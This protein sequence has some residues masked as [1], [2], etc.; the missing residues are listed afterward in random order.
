MN[1]TLFLSYT[2]HDAERC[3]HRIDDQLNQPSADLFRE[4]TDFSR[5]L[6]LVWPGSTPE[7]R[8]NQFRLACYHQDLLIQEASCD[9]LTKGL[10]KLGLPSGYLT[11]PAIIATFHV[12]SYRILGQ[13]LAL[14]RIPFSLLVSGA[15]K[16]AQEAIYWDTVS[17]HL[18]HETD[19]A[20][21]NA[22]DPGV[23]FAMRRS[24][25]AGHC[26][27][28]YLDGNVGGMSQSHLVNLGNLQFRVPLGIGFLAHLMDVP[29]FPIWT[30]RV[31]DGLQLLLK[32]PYLPLQHRSRDKRD[33]ISPAKL[34]L[35]ML[36]DQFFKDLS[37]APWQ[38]EGWFYLDDFQ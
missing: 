18:R 15:V 16:E 21:L 17:P 9:E 13:W 24:L 34:C 20:V 26:I 4:W 10:S 2:H 31:P 14:Q 11:K 30:A 8:T 22:D 29:V 27:L 3:L 12:G 38:W 36:F 35:E 28:A 25:G 1:H 6:A 33:Y 32:A 19:F 5:H 37:V 7:W 23:L